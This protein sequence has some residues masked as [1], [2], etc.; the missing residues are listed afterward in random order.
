MIVFWCVLCVLWITFSCIII[1]IIPRMMPAGQMISDHFAA[2]VLGPASATAAF[3]V[4]TAF[5]QTEG[6]I[7]F[8]GLGFEFEGAA[9]PVVLWVV[10]FLATVAGIKLIW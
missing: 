1:W 5:R 10:C 8:K 6:P 7:K 9:G 4:V 2:V 3:V